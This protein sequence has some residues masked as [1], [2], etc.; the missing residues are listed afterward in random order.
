[1]EH[2]VQAGC[3][4]LV[5][6]LR[7]ATAFLVR[8]LVL[9]AAVGALCGIAGLKNR[10]PGTVGFDIVRRGTDVNGF[11]KYDV[12]SADNGIGDHVLR[13]LAPTDPAPG[14]PHNFLYVLPV[15]AG[16]GTRYG[17][18]LRT[19]RTLDAQNQYN[20]TILEPSFGIESWYA[21]HPTNSRLRYET[22]MT[23]DLV[24]WVRQHLA[25]T[26]REQNWLIGF[27]KSGIGAQDLILKHPH[28]FTLAASWDFPADMS[29]YNQYYRSANS[30]G[31]DAN[32]RANYRLTRGF[33]RAHK[34]PFL[35]SNRIWI[36]GYSRFQTDMSDYD[37]LLTSEGVAHSVATPQPT[38]HSWWSGWVR[39]ALAALRQDSMNLSRRTPVSPQ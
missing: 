18:G 38:A 39:M 7:T 31:T 16:L 26:G 20:L 8:V 35:D 22:F 24:P 23:R 1:M 2:A 27:S 17:D 12:K 15:E 5:I 30:Y 10:S 33:V 36:G 3:R 28:L 32:F 6:V 14:V 4:D 25:R 11:T 37:A 29:T 19:L 9:A 34:A 21:D 13:V